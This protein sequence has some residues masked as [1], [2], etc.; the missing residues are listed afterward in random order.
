MFS[1]VMVSSSSGRRAEEGVGR[2]IDGRRLRD[3]QRRQVLGVCRGEADEEQGN[4]QAR[5]I[6][7]R[8]GA[9][10][11]PASPSGGNCIGLG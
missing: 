5:F 9:L 4:E 6:H 1:W 7:G 11:M 2:D 8:R 10:T 3:D